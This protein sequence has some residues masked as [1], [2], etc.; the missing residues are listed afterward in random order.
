MWN[1]HKLVP[2]ITYG[3]AIIEIQSLTSHFFKQNAACI[4]TKK[5]EST[6]SSYLQTATA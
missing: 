3:K 1:V 2:A 6:K 4:L 5:P